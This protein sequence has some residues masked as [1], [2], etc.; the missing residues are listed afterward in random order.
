MPGDPPVVRPLAELA[1]SAENTTVLE[2]PHGPAVSYLIGPRGATVSALEQAS[3]CRIDVQKTK[4]MV[5]GSSARNVTVTHPDEERRKLCAELV[6]YKLADFEE[7]AK[8]PK[9]E[10]VAEA[11]PPPSGKRQRNDEYPLLM[12][13]ASPGP[14]YSPQFAPSVVPQSP[15]GSAQW[16]NVNPVAPY[17]DCMGQNGA[18]PGQYQMLAQNGAAPAQ[19]Y[20]MQQQYGMP[21]QQAMQPQPY[22]MAQ[23]PSPTGFGQQGYGGLGMQPSPSMQP[24]PMYSAGM[25]A[26]QMA[27]QP[28]AWN[29]MGMA[30]SVRA[31]VG[32]SAPGFPMGVGS[33]IGGAGVNH[34]YHGI[35]TNGVQISSQTSPGTNTVVLEVPNGQAVSYIIGTKGATIHSLQATSGCKVHIQKAEDMQPGAVYRLVT[36]TSPDVTKRNHC[37]D[38]ICSKLGEL[39]RINPS[40]LDGFV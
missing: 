16:P 3:G 32:P 29:P 26:A 1:A 18:Q 28:P 24:P 33:G 35:P 38:M 4:D 25:P 21:Q 36:V 40:S 34:G 17:Y 14:S 39:R 6:R 13:Q 15:A 11:A 20:G 12:E 23:M 8:N 37:I 2:V 5:P 10:P 27:Q 31:L 9:S 19:Q 7:A 22:G 30:P